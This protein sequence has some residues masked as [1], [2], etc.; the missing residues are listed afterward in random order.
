[1]SWLGDGCG[2]MLRTPSAF[3]NHPHTYGINDQDDPL[4]AKHRY[5][6]QYGRAFKGG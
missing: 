4:R 1:M 5:L 6:G 3:A 2:S